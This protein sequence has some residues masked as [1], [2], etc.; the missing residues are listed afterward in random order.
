MR[1]MILISPRPVSIW[2]RGKVKVE[3]DR[4]VPVARRP[5][6]PFEFYFSDDERTRKDESTRSLPYRFLQVKSS[7]V[8]AVVKFCEEYG[9]LGEFS[10]EGW[11]A[12]EKRIVEALTRKNRNRGGN[13]PFD[14]L[15]EEINLRK[16]EDRVAGIQP[17]SVLARSMSIDQFQRAQEQLL[18][19]IRWIREGEKSRTSRAGKEALAKVRLRF[20]EKLAMV[21]PSVSWDQKLER[22]VTG[23]DAGS[24]ESLLYLML[25]YDRQGPGEIKFCPVCENVFKADLKTTYCSEKCG[26]RYRVAKHR[27]RKRYKSDSRKENR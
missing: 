11:R 5:Y 15:Q 6:N 20:G 16:L 8:G 7:D 21:R 14:K 19:T 27:K 26:V 24:L 1:S 17:L 13:S 25:F 3:G 10:L 22:W 9:V 4:I 18:E 12:W 2:W 23:W